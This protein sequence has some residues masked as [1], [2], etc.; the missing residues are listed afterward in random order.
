MTGTYQIDQDVKPFTSSTLKETLQTQ[1]FASKAET[2][3]WKVGSAGM[4]TSFGDVFNNEKTSTDTYTG[5]VGMLTISDI[6]YTSS[7]TDV[8]STI[9]NN[10]KNIGNSWLM[11]T[12]GYAL[13]QNAYV[14][15]NP[16]DY[17]ETDK[18]YFYYVT[19]S[20]PLFRNTATTNAYTVYPTIYLPADAEISGGSGTD[21]RPY[22]INI[23]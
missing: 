13:T 12:S 19:R 22:I 1:S 5:K 2:V 8:S 9:V 4:N 16:D 3:I 11:K 21:S 15:N 14:M 18:K 20:S 17:S 6:A 23:N 7:D 10:L